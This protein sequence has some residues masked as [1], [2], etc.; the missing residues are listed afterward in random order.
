MRAK[1]TFKNTI[2][3]FAYEAIAIVCS[4]ILP[5]LILASF[6]SQY[7]GVTSAISQFLRVISLFQ[8]GIGGVTIAALYRPLVENN[9]VQISVI[10][11]TTESFLRRVVLIFFGFSLVLACL[12]PF[13][14]SSAFDWFFTASLVMI[15]SISTFAQYFFGQTYQFLLKAG[16]LFLL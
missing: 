10:I 16:W 3:G 11:K 7:N 13:L 14:V 6:G 15:M 2:W 12:Y 5:R 9:T 4:F 8:A 1:K